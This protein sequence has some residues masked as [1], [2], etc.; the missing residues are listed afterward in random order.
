MNGAVSLLIGRAQSVDGAVSL[1][2]VYALLTA[3][4]PW[5]LAAIY[6]EVACVPGTYSGTKYCAWITE[7]LTGSDLPYTVQVTKQEYAAL[8]S[9]ALCDRLASQLREKGRNPYI[10]PVGGSNAVSEGCFSLDATRL[11]LHWVHSMHALLSDDGW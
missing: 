5:E 2:I 1:S 8:G 3:Q 7:P 4:A 6:S 10:I 9:V 11:C